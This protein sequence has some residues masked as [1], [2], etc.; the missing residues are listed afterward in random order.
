[1][2][3]LEDHRYIW[4]IDPQSKRA[5]STSSESSFWQRNLPSHLS[6][7]IPEKVQVELKNGDRLHPLST[8]IPDQRLADDGTQPVQESKAAE[9]YQVYDGDDL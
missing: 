5:Q 8:G 4:E 3:W 9:S 1:M 6:L 2:R 7:H